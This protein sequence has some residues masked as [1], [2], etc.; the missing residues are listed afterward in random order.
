M[1]RSTISA[2][3]LGFTEQKI[4]VVTIHFKYRAVTG[5]VQPSSLIVVACEKIRNLKITPSDL[6]GSIRKFRQGNLSL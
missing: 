3:R 6:A 1:V 5:V 4:C 2:Q